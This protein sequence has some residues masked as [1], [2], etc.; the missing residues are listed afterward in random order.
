MD[1]EISERLNRAFGKYNI[2]FECIP[3]YIHRQIAAERAIGTF[4]NHVLAGLATCHKQIPIAKWDRLLPQAKITLK[5]LR[6]CRLNPA[7][8]AYACLWGPYDFN[9][10][11]IA[12]PGTMTLVHKKVEDRNLWDF[13]C[14]IGWYIGPALHHYICVQ[15]YIPSTNSVNVADTVKFIEEKIPF[16][17]SN[18]DDFLK[19]LIS[20]IV[21]LLKKALKNEHTSYQVR[22]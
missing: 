15:V 18:V 14:Q 9:A 11:L 1:N 12:P 7:L 19:Q 5:L 10:H 17:N 3:P 16:P 21:H 20:D 4:K 8:S 6:R 22:H 13:H 2:T